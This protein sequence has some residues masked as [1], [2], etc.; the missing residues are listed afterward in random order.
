MQIAQLT[1]ADFEAYR[2]LMLHAYESAPDAF[3]STPEERAEAPESWWIKRLADP[4]G[5]GVAFGAFEHGDLVGTVALELSGKPKTRHKVILIGMFVLAAC[6]G[7]GMGK[8]LVQ[9][10]LQYARSDR[11]LTVM[12][13][14]ATQDNHSA[15]ELYKQCGFI[16]FGTEP[17]AIRTPSGYKAKVHMWQLLTHED[18]E[19]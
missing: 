18:T 12:T 15:I 5:L 4:T 1:A 16:A 10:A 13:L 14:T 2:S 6:R 19:A 8:A 11:Q 17:M 7:K 3:T 9:A